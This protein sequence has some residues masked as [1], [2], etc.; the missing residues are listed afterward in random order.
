MPYCENSSEHS[1]KQTYLST[2]L[3]LIPLKTLRNT[4]ACPKAKAMG[5]TVENTSFTVTSSNREI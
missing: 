1:N 4:T 2:N 5:T 3:S